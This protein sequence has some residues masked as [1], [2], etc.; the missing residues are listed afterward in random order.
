MRA[1]MRCRR[2][3]LLSLLILAGAAGCADNPAPIPAPEDEQPVAVQLK[4]V[5]FSGYQ[6]TLKQFKGKVILVD[7]WENS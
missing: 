7:F 5:D 3:G 2:A 6:D 4:H 1:L